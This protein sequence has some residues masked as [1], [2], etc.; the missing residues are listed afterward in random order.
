VVADLGGEDG[1][2][3]SGDVGRVR[4]DQLECSA[5]RRAPVRRREAGPA[6]NP[7][8]ARVPP[9][10][11]ERRG[12]AVDGDAMGL[13][14]LVQERDQ[15][16]SGAGA[17]VEDAQRRVPAG[18]AG[19]RRLDHGLRVRAGHER[20]RGELEGQAPELPMPQDA[21]DRLVREPAGGVAAQPL[22]ARGPERLPGAQRQSGCADAERFGHKDAGVEAGRVEAG[23]RQG[24]AQERE[25]LR[26]GRC[27]GKRDERIHAAWAASWAAWCSVVSA[28]TISSRAVPSITSSSR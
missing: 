7:V 24:A 21:G 11:R 3:L 2:V 5:E 20:F 17:E 1:N 6:R 8:A 12:G 28:S 18:D 10:G 14:Q 13:R 9:R 22:R 15:K 16:T 27:A 26:A 19:E 25:G 23:V 4:D